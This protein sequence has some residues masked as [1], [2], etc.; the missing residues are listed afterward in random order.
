[1]SINGKN[2]FINT[3]VVPLGSRHF[4]AGN[5]TVSLRDHKDGVFANG[6]H[7][8]LKD[9][10]TGTVTDLSDGN[11]TFMANAGV[12]TGRFEIIYRP[13]TVLAT[14]G[15]QVENL[16]VYRD[17]NDFVVKATDDEIDAIEIYDAVGRLIRLL[18]P[19]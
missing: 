2:K 18:E 16:V 6:Q 11:Y 4:T 7:I 13:E 17:G 12:S 14:D 9:K 5:Y 1:L 8:Y 15:N 10:Q 19:R 3:D